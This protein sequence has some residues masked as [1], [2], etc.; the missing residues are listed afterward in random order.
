M[1]DN[2][3]GMNGRDTEERKFRIDLAGGEMANDIA[4][5]FGGE[6]ERRHPHARLMGVSE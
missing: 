3:V 2:E 1:V 4:N 5:G 6:M